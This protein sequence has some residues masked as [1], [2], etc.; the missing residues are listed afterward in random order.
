MANFNFNPSFPAGVQKTLKERES[1]IKN[2][3][4]GWNYQK[5]A[6]F[7]MRNQ[8]AQTYSDSTPASTS[9]FDVVTDADTVFP[10]GISPK[11]GHMDLYTSEGG[12]RRLKPKITSAKMSLD[13]GG[14]IYNSFIR[15]VEVEFQ[16]FTMADLN[17][18]V[19]NYFRIGARIEIEFGWV[20]STREGESGKDV[21]KV[22]NFGYSM[23]S[24]GSFNCN[25]K[26][27]TGDAFASSATS[28][29]TLTLTDDAEVNALGK[30]G[31]NPADI[32]MALVAKYKA[33][34]GLDPD[35]EAGDAS[36]D[37]GEL[38]EAQDSS[39]NYDLYMAG[40]M[41][42]GESEGFFFGDDPVRTP[43]VRF[44]SFINLAN[45]VSGG[46][47]TETFVFSTSEKTKI[48][49][50][51][52]EFGSADPRKYIFPGELSDYGEDNDYKS[53][54][55]E[56][57]VDIKNI[58]ISINRISE[59]VKNK[60]TTV[61]EKF[62]PPT[63]AS[64][65][66]ELSSEIKFLS[67]G[68]VDIKVVPKTEDASRENESGQ[69]EIVNYTNVVIDDTPPEPYKF[70]VLGETSIVKD[71]SID[72]EFDIDIMTMMTVGNVRNGVSSLQPF[73]N[74]GLYSFPE[75]PVKDS[76]T[77][78]TKQPE[79]Q[80]IPSKEGIG[81]DGIDDSRANSIAS[82]MR[83]KLVSDDVDGTFVTIPFQIKLGIKLDGITGIPFL[84][85]ITIDR[86][87]IN[88]DNSKIH[89]LVMG[90]EQ[91]FDGD[92]GWETDIKTAMKIGK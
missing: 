11:G 89:F 23:G 79:D 22:Y 46:N 82:A 65:I 19:K 81:K 18:V 4:V 43:F 92:G 76:E 80:D 83:E 78:E 84:S 53:I 36:I 12:V 75:I 25:I 73:K 32:S 56:K 61:N 70:S 54:M 39:G 38:Q 17:T 57:E 85:P 21:M 72:T 74:S 41:N 27:L 59:I 24:D 67:G 26:G 86:L 20:G 35:E 8:P 14:D 3:K 71:V 68:L 28:G 63:I 87:P 13:G 62:R 51:E 66:K 7:I 31:V 2:R 44:E 90:V 45:K 52:K 5:T 69:Y 6:Y 58:L 1:D 30:S 64:I 88:Y 60:G 55:G 9:V 49:K 42:T 47:P 15:E 37:N 29:G 40:I 50:N 77:G 48:R 33:A 91:S 10:I 34:F 16:V